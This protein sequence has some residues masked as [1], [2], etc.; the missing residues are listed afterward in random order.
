[1]VRIFGR[2]FGSM[3]KMGRV[4]RVGRRG[5]GR[6]PIFR[7]DVYLLVH[8]VAFALQVCSLYKTSAVTFV[9]YTFTLTY[10]DVYFRHTI[11][12]SACQ[13]T[14]SWKYFFNG[15]IDIARDIGCATCDMRHVSSPLTVIEVTFSSNSHMYQMAN[16]CF[17]S[18]RDCRVFSI[19]SV[20]LFSA[21]VSAVHQESPLCVRR[22]TRHRVTM[23][24]S[25]NQFKWMWVP[26]PFSVLVCFCVSEV[27]EEWWVQLG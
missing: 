26:P 14:P 25:P 3:W 5:W 4:S 19:F 8:A 21:V 6:T 27:S 12:F 11:N 18:K 16:S 15:H 9:V 22:F 20:V 24:F 2:I 10:L 13:M 17:L 1:M 23:S 7:C